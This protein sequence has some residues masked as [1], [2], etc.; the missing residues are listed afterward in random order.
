MYI[1][2]NN[3]H[4]HL[5]HV[6][7]YILHVINIVIVYLWTPIYIYNVYCIRLYYLNVISAHI[8]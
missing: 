1:Q 7:V 4:V 8:K 2:Q 5:L 6:H 3:V